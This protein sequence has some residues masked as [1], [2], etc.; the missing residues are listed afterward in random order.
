MCADA[1]A[2]RMGSWTFIIAQ[3]VLYTLWILDNV[4]LTSGHGQWDPYPF[5]LLG[6]VLTAVSG[7]A[8]PIIMMS[9]Y[10]QSE[11]AR[12]QAELDQ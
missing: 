12:I 9:Q 6:L 2:S 7:Y 1:F 3:S 5:G 10:R 8:A 4:L 11:K